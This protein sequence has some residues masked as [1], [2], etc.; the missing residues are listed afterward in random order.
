MANVLLNEISIRSKII[1]AG[2]KKQF[3]GIAKTNAN[4]RL[5]FAEQELLEDFDNHQVTKELNPKNVSIEGS[6]LID[7]GNLFSFIGFPEDS[8]PAQE[9]RDYLKDNITIGNEP[10]VTD[11]GR[12]II[13]YNFKVSVPSMNQINNEE[14]FQ[15]PDNW[16]S[17]SWIEIIENGVSNAVYYI[18]AGGES[19]AEKFREAGSRSGWGLQ[20]KDK[21]GNNQK[22]AAGGSFTPMK[23]ISELLD[24]F[25][26]RFN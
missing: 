21:D 1:S 4:T 12:N 23:Y 24:N 10:K 19:N 25:R 18:F 22:R 6:E 14:A 9:L 16:R 15:T 7:H 3:I 26:K 13:Y 11:N 17:S 20:R 5:I 8:N 2:K